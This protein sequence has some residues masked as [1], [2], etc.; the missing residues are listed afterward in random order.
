[1]CIRDRHTDILINDLFHDFVRLYPDKFNNKT[2]GI[3]HQM[4]IRD[5]PCAVRR[6]RK[7]SV[8]RD[9]GFR[10]ILCG[11]GKSITH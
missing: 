6:S 11:S 9:S 7:D 2:N 5:S 10:C 8:W 4:C 1:M 3:T